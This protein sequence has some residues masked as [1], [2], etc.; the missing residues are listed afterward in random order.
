MESLNS[1][2]LLSGMHHLHRSFKIFVS[3]GEF[4]W[5]QH[6]VCV[7]LCYKQ[8]VWFRIGEICPYFWKQ[9]MPQPKNTEHSLALLVYMPTMKKRA[10]KMGKK[11]EL[12][13]LKLSCRSNTLQ[14]WTKP[15]FRKG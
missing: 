7:L 13:S 10:T 5:T 2:F 15:Q 14:R 12:S 11:L 4:G 3:H 6:N 1:K 8:S 9:N